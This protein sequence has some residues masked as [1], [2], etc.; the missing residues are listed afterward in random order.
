MKTKFNVN[1]IVHIN[2]VNFAIIKIDSFGATKHYGVS[3]LN[4]NTNYYEYG[5]IPCNIL[6]TLATLR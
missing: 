3:W 6:D 5:W 1:Q 4:R 2:D